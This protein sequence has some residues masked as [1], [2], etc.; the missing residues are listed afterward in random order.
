MD[1][2]ILW[3][4]LK[5][6]FS[7]HVRGSGAYRDRIKWPTRT[8]PALARARAV[9]ACAYLADGITLIITQA[10]NLKNDEIYAALLYILRFFYVGLKSHIVSYAW[11][12]R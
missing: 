7:L 5:G 2:D 4:V 8:A 10:T 1:R 3:T 11:A 6:R 12:F 9:C